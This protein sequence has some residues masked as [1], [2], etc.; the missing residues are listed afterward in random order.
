MGGR[1]R[2]GEWQVELPPSARDPRDAIRAANATVDSSS[3]ISNGRTFQDN[4]EEYPA[5]APSGP[6]SLT[7]GNWGKLSTKSNKKQDF[8]A[9]SSGYERTVSNGRSFSGAA[10]GS[11]IRDGKVGGSG[12]NGIVSSS[13]K[14]KSAS[15]STATATS[16][17]TSTSMSVAATVEESWGITTKSDKRLRPNG[18]ISMSKSSTTIGMAKASASAGLTK[19]AAENVGK[20]DRDEETALDLKGSDYPSLSM[21]PRPK[22]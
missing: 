6:G 5:L 15:A 2:G 11:Y 22:K 1:A 20:W 9:L 12:S 18:G 8:P 16:T 7:I 21:A 10:V 3:F 17:S 13:T 4:E 14:S 19:G